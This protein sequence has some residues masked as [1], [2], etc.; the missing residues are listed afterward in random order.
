MCNLFGNVEHRKCFF[1]VTKRG[2][3][4][5]SYLWINIH[6]G[7]SVLRFQ[8]QSISTIVIYTYGVISQIMLDIT[9]IAKAKY[10]RAV[11]IRAQTN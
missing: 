3:M 9:H 6:S 7:Y 2:K 10:S 4:F 11:V 1:F 5:F 8:K